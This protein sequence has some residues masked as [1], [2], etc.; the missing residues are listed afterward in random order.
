M[1]ENEL[2]PAGT[3]SL[4]VPSP[5]LGSLL[6]EIDDLAELKC[7]LRFLWHAAQV[8]GSPKWVRAESLEADGVLLGALGSREAVRSGFAAA[9]A[10]GTLVESGGRYLLGTP[11]NV[12]VAQAG[13]APASERTTTPAEG[14]SGERSNVFAL[15]ETNVGLMTPLVA[16][17]LRDA[18]TEYPAEWIEAAIQ[19]AAER[20]V[21]NWRYI[22]SILE[23][24]AVEGRGPQ[25][26][27][28]QRH[29]E[30]GRHTETASAAEYLRQ[31]RTAG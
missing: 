19:E 28:K 12:R 18:E 2:F 15:Y 17:Q 14:R 10:R 23:R 13:V 26:G 29:G 3:K 7:T 5:L 16:D 20:N 25:K 6:A 27:T 8:K 31:R 11:E 24:W 30:P 22:A 21:R 9:A 1:G 4:P